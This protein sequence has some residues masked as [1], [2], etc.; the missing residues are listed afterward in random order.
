M[1]PLGQTYENND[2]YLV[3]VCSLHK[4]AIHFSICVYFLLL[5]GK[6]YFILQIGKPSNYT[7]P[8]I[9][10]DFGVHGREWISISTATYVIY[11]VSVEYTPVDLRQRD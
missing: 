6:F 2:I 7:K 10:V 9:W 8:A 3:K 1:F 4:R 11:R 5:G